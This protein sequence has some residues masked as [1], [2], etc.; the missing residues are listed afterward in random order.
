MKK[1]PKSNKI[2]TSA[3]TWAEEF[4]LAGGSYSVSDIQDYFKHIL[5]R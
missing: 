1:S 5:K 2:K 3:P 4:E